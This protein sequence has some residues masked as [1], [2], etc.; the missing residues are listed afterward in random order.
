MSAL[1]PKADMCGALGHVCFGPKADIGPEC[2]NRLLRLAQHVNLKAQSKSRATLAL[3]KRQ[4]ELPGTSYLYNLT[5]I[6][7]TFAGF[8]ALIAAFRQMVGGRLTRYDAFLI[9]SALVRSLIVI[10]SALLPP[11]LAL[12]KLSAPAIWRV[13]SLTAAILIA[14]FTLSWPLIRRAVKDAPFPI[15]AKLY[16]YIQALTAIFLLMVAL[17][18]LFEPAAG[19]FAA[20]VSVFM[21]TSW[22]AV[23]LSLEILLDVDPRQRKPK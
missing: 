1:P 23:L 14:L 4:M 7:V 6:S 2:R 17:G 15:M 18:I 10:I 9:F 19:P 8:A 3:V 12:F 11:L 5:M 13:S 20:G 21:L 16:F 22:F